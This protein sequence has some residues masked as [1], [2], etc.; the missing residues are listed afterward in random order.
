MPKSC[1]YFAAVFSCASLVVAEPVV[2][3]SNFDPTAGRSEYE[4][5]FP[6]QLGGGTIVMPI[7][8][9]TFE[10]ETDAEAGTA[11]LLSWTQEVD[12]IDLYGMNTGPIT[13]AM[14][15]TAPSE[16][17]YDSENQQFSVSATFLISFDDTELRNVGFVSPVPLVGIE[18]GTIYGVGSIGTI[19]MF[20]Q[21]EGSVAGSTFIY[22]CRTSAR[23]EYA[24]ADDQAQPGDV[25]QD[26]SLD[27]TDAMAILLSLF[28]GQP[29]ACTSA[30]DVNGDV[31]VNISDPI[32]L[33]DYLFSGGPA[34]GAEPTT[35]SGS[36]A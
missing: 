36:D 27:M 9:G 8:G 3:K 30:G 26:R 4:V 17:T 7:V 31:D 1:L 18:Q 19:Q 33:L 16:G 6:P 15:T 28:Q 11:R 34:P 2:R 22:T 5:L 12:A 23:F 20:L 35:C 21:G 13:I 25:N 24:L 32:F 14:D 29:L 10:L